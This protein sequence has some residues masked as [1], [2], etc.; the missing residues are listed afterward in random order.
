MA[1]ILRRVGVDVPEQ[2]RRFLEGDLDSWLRVEE[3]QEHNT[4]AVK[5]EVGNRP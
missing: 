1:S 5:A 4:L 3:Y 2:V